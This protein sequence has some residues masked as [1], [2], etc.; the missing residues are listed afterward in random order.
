MFIAEHFK[1]ISEPE[2]MNSP[3]NIE[4]KFDEIHMLPRAQHFNF[5]LTPRINVLTRKYL[6]I[7]LMKFTCCLY[8]SILNSSMNQ[9]QYTRQ[10]ILEIKF[11]EIHTLL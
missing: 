9:S 5:V 4:T 3:E 10:K 2:P 7:N 11:D 6:E 8:V 1:F